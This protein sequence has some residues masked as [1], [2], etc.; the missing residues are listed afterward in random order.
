[1]Q[2]SSDEDESSSIYDMLEDQED[3]TEQKIE[4]MEIK[5]AIEKALAELS[6]R[7]RKIVEM[8]FG[9]IDGKARTLIEVGKEERVTRERIRQIEAGALKKLRDMQNLRQ[10][11]DGPIEKR[12]GNQFHRQSEGYTKQQKAGETR[13]MMGTGYK[14]G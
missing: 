14:R 9:L 8:R 11:C 5:E 7:E 2:G 1:M 10:L 12:Q 13:K 3:Y 6:S 4:A